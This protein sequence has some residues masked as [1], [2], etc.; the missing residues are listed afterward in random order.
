MAGTSGHRKSG[1][2]L[3]EVVLGMDLPLDIIN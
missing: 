3:V 1:E 2:T